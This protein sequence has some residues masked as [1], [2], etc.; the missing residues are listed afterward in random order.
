MRP[1]SYA[2]PSD[3]RE[4]IETAGVAPEF[5]FI[6]GGTD[7][8]N[9]MKDQV[10]APNL[11]VDLNSAGLGEISLIDNDLSLGAT[12]RMAEVA[13]HPQVQRD[14]PVIA[15]AL[16]ASA[17]GQ[18]RNMASIGGNLLQSTRC[19][20]FRDVAMPCNARVAGSGCPA[21]TGENR[22]HAIF[23]GSDSC[24]RVHPSD[25]AVALHAVDA[26]VVTRHA[27]GSRTIPINELYVLPGSAPH[28]QTVLERG[29]LITSVKIPATGLAQRSRYVKVRDRGS[30]EF[31]L[32]SVAVAL[33]TVDGVVRDAR[34]AL[35]GVAPRP[36]RALGAEA[37][38]LR[39][40]L[41]PATIAAAGSAATDGAIPLA[42]NAFKL[43]LVKRTVIRALTEAGEVR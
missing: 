43:E 36:W 39:Q 29:E 25:L 33:D 31:A 14:C 10:V 38:L 8:L 2:L 34:V 40:R 27:A 12:S 20:Y 41:D 11:L 13:S 16:L 23:G 5:A 32:V 6:A 17:S 4:A 21:I 26:M 15:E 35:G 37:A 18:I 28:R 24:V 19:W 30:F 1:F 42:G 9:L 22:M 7:L 3:S